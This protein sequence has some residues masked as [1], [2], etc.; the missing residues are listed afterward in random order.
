MGR[1]DI[2]P[3]RIV[4]IAAQI[5]D[6]DGTLVTDKKNLSV[7]TKGTVEALHSAGIAFGI[8]VLGGTA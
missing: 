1:H 8:K 3:I 2:C 6:V 4:Q 7:R 5:S